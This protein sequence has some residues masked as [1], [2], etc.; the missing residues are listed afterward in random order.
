MLRTILPMMSFIWTLTM[1]L[2]ASLLI[3]LT[4]NF[5]GI[6]LVYMYS[7]VAHSSINCMMCGYTNFV[8]GHFGYKNAMVPIPEM[9]QKEN[10]FMIKP[11]DEDWQRL[12]ATTGQPSFLN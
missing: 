12:L 5:A 3:L 1:Q 2:E 10:K 7:Q 9:M 8:C 6:F 11:E 4:L